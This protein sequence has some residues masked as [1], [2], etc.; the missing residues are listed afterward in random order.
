MRDYVTADDV[1]TTV[2]A[3]ID[4]LLPA[5]DRDWSVP[6]GAL[7]WTC[8][9]TAEHIADDLFAYAVQLGPAKPSAT[10]YVPV[11]WERKYDGAPAA[12]IYAEKKAGVTGLL[13]VLEACGA[14]LT[15]MVRVTPPEKRS[16]HSSGLSDV[17][18]F[19]ALG[20]VEVI[21]HTHDIATGLGVAW[22]PQLD[23]CERVL[24][25]LFSDIA[26]GFPAAETFLWATG[27]GELPGQPRLTSW[28]VDATPR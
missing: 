12:S 25:R 6:A 24:S 21:A 22:N 5:A 8:W 26:A 1:Q 2:A 3:A 9:E 27:R 23:V 18:G 16:F 19:A 28:R 14:L 11:A 4:A 20:C 17:E 13:E 15:A 10:T 7:M